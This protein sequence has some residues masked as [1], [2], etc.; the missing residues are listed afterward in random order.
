M[1]VEYHNDRILLL[2]AMASEVEGLDVNKSLAYGDESIVYKDQL[3]SS[4]DFNH[5]LRE[6]NKAMG[7]EKFCHAKSFCMGGWGYNLFTFEESDLAKEVKVKKEAE[8][9]VE[10]IEMEV[11]D[12]VST[13]VVE[14][15]APVVV[16]EPDWEWIATLKNNKDDK[17]ALDKYAEAEFGI[18]LN[19]QMKLDNMI[20]AFKEELEK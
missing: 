10:D 15:E 12:I 20:K 6:L 16:K 14:D 11:V 1:K 9:V 7:L 17:L 8:E 13:E 2:Q 3:I 18:S 4:P 5:M 19:R